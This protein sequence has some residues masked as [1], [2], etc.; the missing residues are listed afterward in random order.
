[1]IEKV[2]GEREEI[3]EI[4]DQDHMIGLPHMIE[5]AHMIGQKVEKDPIVEIE[6]VEIEI[7]LRTLEI[8]EKKRTIQALDIPQN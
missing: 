6:V 4:E 1:M 7:E 5:Q 3:V 2:E 8:Q